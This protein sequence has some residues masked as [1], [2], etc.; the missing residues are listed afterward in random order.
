MRRLVPILTMTVLAL[1]ACGGTTKIVTETVTTSKP[2]MVAP[3]EKPTTTRATTAPDPVIPKFQGPTK[4]VPQPKPVSRFT[5]CDKNIRARTAT[6]TCK[7]AENVFYEYWTYW[8]GDSLGVV[9]Y[10]PVTRRDY[11]M[12][13]SEGSTVICK[14]ADGGEVR[15]SKA[16]VER[17]REDQAASY[18]AHADTGPL[19]HGE[20]CDADPTAPDSTTP[21]PSSPAP[22]A[23][24][25]S[26]TVPDTPG[27]CDT[28][29]CIPNYGNGNGSTV[30]C[31]DGTYSHS[32]GIQGACSHHGG[33]G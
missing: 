25:T 7:F 24:D 22:A 21:T 19:C 5:Y 16:A 3:G 26:P 18:E 12:T 8:H 1:A 14:A 15:F 9:A 28:H 11:A 20:A 6:T 32:G 31:E 10:S 2:T 13:C 17:Y 23:P 4:T 29:A 33:V 27:F 30:Q